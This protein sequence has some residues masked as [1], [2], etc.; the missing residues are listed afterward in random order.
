MCNGGYTHYRKNQSINLR[1]MKRTLDKKPLWKQVYERLK[2]RIEQGQYADRFYL[3]TESELMEEF[4]CSRVTIRKAMEELTN[5]GYITRKR[6]SGT[7]IAPHQVDL[8]TTLQ[9]KVI[10][11]F[12]DRRD[13]RIINISYEAA[14]SEV[15][16]FFK[17]PA[18]NTVLKLERLLYAENKPI[19]VNTIFLNLKPDKNGNIDFSGSLY[20]TLQ[21]EGY[22][23][24]E[25]TERFTASCTNDR[26][27][28][29]LGLDK[30][31]IVMRRERRGSSG[32]VPVEYSCSAYLADDYELTVR[33]HK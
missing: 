1:N 4:S 16:S 17:I 9:T 15:S 27:Q 32:N 2:K 12:N 19:A 33:Y 31:A 21:K 24:T 7:T 23:V 25:I 10:D 28:V 8:S 20:K 3:P 14:P 29:L 11:E 22:P 18:E 13:R 5:E 26:E 30:P 6:G